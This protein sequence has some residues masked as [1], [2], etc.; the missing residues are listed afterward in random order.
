MCN[1]PNRICEDCLDNLKAAYKF[2]MMCTKSELK[3]QQLKET[4]C[5][6]ERRNSGNR[7]K[8]KSDN[9]ITLGNIKTEVGKPY[10]SYL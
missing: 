7:T 8:I 2:C 5:K 4:C 6:R 10:Y 1:L 3:L 9:E